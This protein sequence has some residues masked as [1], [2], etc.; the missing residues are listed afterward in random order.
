MVKAQLSGYRGK[1]NTQHK[2]YDKPIDNITLK[3]E[4]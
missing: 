3:S 2:P 4:S 1:E